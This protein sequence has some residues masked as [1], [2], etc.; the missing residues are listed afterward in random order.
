MKLS[1]AHTF[2]PELIPR[3][4]YI[5][6]VK[7]MYGKLDGDVIGGGRS[8]YTL[9]PTARNSLAMA[10]SQAHAAD[11]KYNYLLNGA[12][13]GGMEQTRA[14]QRSIR[15]L[16]DWVASQQVDAVTVASPYLLRLVK[17]LYP[18]LAVRVG[19]FALVDNAVK[20]RGWEDL[21]A[22]T[23]CISAISCNRDFDR[24]STIR[25]ATSCELQL[26]VNANCQ[27]NCPYELTHMNMLTNSSR[28]G[29]RLNGFC[30][31]Y[32]FLNCSARK[33]TDPIN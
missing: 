13:L 19:V 23:L 8:S 11:M 28:T 1:V 18:H 10:V 31:D 26:I 15:R 16:I 9:R 21:G 32:C 27:I 22:D 17:Y 29:D 25:N 33:L 5:P 24:L 4:S 7:E 12:T 3:L 14:G 30:L 6:S 20:A 2:D